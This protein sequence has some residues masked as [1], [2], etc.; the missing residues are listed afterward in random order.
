VR[1]PIIFDKV[2]VA[3][4]MLPLNE[5]DSEQKVSQLQSVPNRFAIQLRPSVRSKVPEIPII[6][7]VHEL[8]GSIPTNPLRKYADQPFNIGK[9][10][11]MLLFQVLHSG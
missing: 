5:A 3:P 6:D 8:L 10:V 4:N 11:P 9:L 7:Q 1:A 2:V